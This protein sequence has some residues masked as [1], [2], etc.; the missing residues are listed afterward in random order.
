MKEKNVE[1][2]DY[3]VLLVRHKRFLISVTFI[4]MVIFYLAI[5]FFVDERF[6]GRTVI[7]PSD[8]GD[9][10]GIAAMLGDL[11][12]G[13]P[14]GL[15]GGS[16]EDAVNKYNAIIFSRSNLEKIARKFNLQEKYGTENMEETVRALSS[17]IETDMVEDYA[18]EI[19]GTA[20]SREEAAELTNYIVSLLNR[21]VLELNVEKSR[22][23]RIFLEGRH[24][25]IRQALK[26]AEDSL[27]AYQEKT[28]VF[29]ATEQVKATIEAFAGM[30]TELARE[31]AKLAVMEEIFGADSK[32]AKNVRYTVEELHQNINRLKR[33][34]GE[35]DF[36]LSVKNIPSN[37][38]NYFRYLREVEI[39]QAMLEFIVPLYEQAKIEEQKDIPV[40]QVLDEAVPP[41]KKSFPPRTIFTLL[42]GFSVFLITF[43]FILLK[44]NRK[45]QD[46]EKMRYVKNNLFRLK[47]KPL[48]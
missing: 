27:L 4:T 19:L 10:S 17:D 43:L 14:F 7:V 23:N 15:G 39:N 1:L 40:L 30:E 38:V 5:F 12:G 33:G 21:S 20:F 28:G 44:E 41:E 22:Q 9:M 35:Q 29:E 48:E 46:S 3:V 24:D 36:L 25:S 16:N 8:A 11:G 32:Q 13:L 18:F 6:T 26:A 34:E 31:R 47:S 45:W 2:L 42:V 37:A